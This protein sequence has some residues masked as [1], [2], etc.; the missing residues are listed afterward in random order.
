[1]ACIYLVVVLFFCMYAWFNPDGEC[2]AHSDGR[3]V[4]DINDGESID[5]A[6]LFHNWFVDFILLLI[7]VPILAVYIYCTLTHN[8]G[9]P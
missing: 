5:V 4:S 2:Y 6:E 7:L 9:V 3:H 1:M 8:M